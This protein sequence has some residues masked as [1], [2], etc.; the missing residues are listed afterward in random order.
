V[1]SACA[2][3]RSTSAWDIYLI[4]EKAKYLGKV[5]AASAEEAI[6]IAQRT[7]EGLSSEQEKRLSAQPAR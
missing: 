7:F 4:R 2:L 3:A 6:A 1:C 5:E